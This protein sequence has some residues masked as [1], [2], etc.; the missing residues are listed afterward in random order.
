MTKHVAKKN[1]VVDNLLPHLY[2]QSIPK[3]SYHFKVIETVKKEF[4]M[5]EGIE[6][7]LHEYNITAVI[8]SE[9]MRRS[10]PS[11]HIF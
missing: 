9:Y 2:F 7:A 4:P 5:Q 11:Y 3:I 8:I 10:T 6:R 1:S